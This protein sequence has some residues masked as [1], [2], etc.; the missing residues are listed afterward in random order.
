MSDDSVAAIV[1]EVIYYKV[2]G[3][4]SFRNSILSEI[5]EFKNLVI[6]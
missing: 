5:G 4:H 1:G 2:F 3:N 6:I